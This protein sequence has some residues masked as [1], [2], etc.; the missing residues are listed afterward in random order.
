[1]PNNNIKKQK[2]IKRIYLS[3]SV[4]QHI[5]SS[6]SDRKTSHMGNTVEINKKL[7]VAI[8]LYIAPV[9]NPRPIFNKKKKN[10][11]KSINQLSL[12]SC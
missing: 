4:C 5:F 9:N 7:N 2:N 10:K 3:P 12:F 6:N 1:M 11:T 8:P